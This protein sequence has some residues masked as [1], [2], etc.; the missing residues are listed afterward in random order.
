MKPH[1]HYFE[2]H[3]PEELQ[4]VE[5]TI[6][7]LGTQVAPRGK[8]TKEIRNIVVKFF[9]ECDF[10]PAHLDDPKKVTE[11]GKR[12][13]IRDM[14]FAKKRITVIRHKIIFEM[15]ETAKILNEDAATRRARII[16][17]DYAPYNIP[18]LVANQFFR[19]NGALEMSVFLRSSDLINVL[20]LDIYAMQA[21]QQDILD[22]RAEKAK[23]P[24]FNLD[25]GPI[26]A[27]I[28]SSH[29]YLLDG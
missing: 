1:N 22:A 28:A 27:L 4:V 11:E 24:M 13:Y 8:V 18:C 10:D 20:P 9:P 21:L 17:P 15:N 23:V 29:V 5:K 26:T 7:S 12:F 6:L 25:K 14:P 2:V 19:R 16:E 3:R